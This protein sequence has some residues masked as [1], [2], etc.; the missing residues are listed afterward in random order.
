MEIIVKPLSIDLL[1]DFLY[2]F[3]NIGFTDNPEWSV[4]T[5]TNSMDPVID[6]TSNAIEI[7]PKQAEDIHVGDIVAYQS[8]YNS[9]DLMI[10]HS[11]RNYPPNST[12]KCL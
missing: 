8:K 1:D 6:S 11:P 3:D 7:I 2:Y 12:S 4:F 10:C 9:L 5:D